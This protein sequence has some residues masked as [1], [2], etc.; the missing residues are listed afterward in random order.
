MVNCEGVTTNESKTFNKTTQEENPFS[1]FPVLENEFYSG[2]QKY[3][4]I[5]ADVFINNKLQS[6]VIDSGAAVSLINIKLV[7]AMGLSMQPHNGVPIKAV[8]G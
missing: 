1:I 2:E 3:Y 6:A 5:L 4:P 7:N 8:S